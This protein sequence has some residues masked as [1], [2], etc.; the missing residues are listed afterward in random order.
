MPIKLAT[1]TNNR[2]AVKFGIAILG[3]CENKK[4]INDIKILG[5]HDEFSV[6]STVALSNYQTI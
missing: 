6:F 2:N 1:K 3:L 4:P 5:L